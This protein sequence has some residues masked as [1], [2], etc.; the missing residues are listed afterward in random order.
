MQRRNAIGH[1][2]AVEDYGFFAP[3]KARAGRRKANWSSVGRSSGDVEDEIAGLETC[4]HILQQDRLL[5]QNRL[6]ITLADLV[7]P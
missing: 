5:L 4:G 1:S 3:V 7:A 2:L 6:S